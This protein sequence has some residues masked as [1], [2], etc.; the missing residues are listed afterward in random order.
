MN[1]R[2]HPSGNSDNLTNTIIIRAGSENQVHIA[3]LEA[4]QT[5]EV[6]F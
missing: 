2:E 6:G 5:Y 3:Y 4:R 1:L